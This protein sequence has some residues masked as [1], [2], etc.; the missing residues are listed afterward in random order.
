LAKGYPEVVQG[1]QKL[2]ID[3]V[4][5]D[6]QQK[7]NNTKTDDASHALTKNIDLSSNNYI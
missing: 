2:K 5:R 7:T 4:Y 1:P 3:K 6:K